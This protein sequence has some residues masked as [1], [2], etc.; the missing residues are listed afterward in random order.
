MFGP[1]F[2]W[3]LGQTSCW[4]ASTPP[5]AFLTPARERHGDRPPRAAADDHELC[6]LARHQSLGDDSH[7]VLAVVDGNARDR[8]DR[9]PAD[10]QVDAVEDYV[11]AAR[12]EA[13]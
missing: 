8:D 10:T 1:R 7:H 2:C 11:V 5:P 4:R 12:H 9:V 3:N 6:R 13:G